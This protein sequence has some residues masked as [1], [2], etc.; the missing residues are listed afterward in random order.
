MKKYFFLL[1]L[2]VFTTIDALAQHSISGVVVDENQEVLIGVSVLVKGSTTSVTITDVNGKYSF[3][4]VPASS[5]LVFSYVGKITQEQRITPSMS[6]LNI[7]MQSSA[8][9]IDE[10]VVTAMGIQQEKKRMN[11]AV[12]SI[13]SDLLTEN[14]SQNFVNALQGKIAG[15]SVTNSSG[16]P[17]SGTQVIIRGISSMNN[18]Q[19]NEPLFILDGIPLA[20]KGSSAADINPN[21]IE[22]VTVLKGAAAAALYGQDAANGVIMITTKK[23]KVGKITATANVSGQYDTP[24][25]LQQ[26]QTSYAPGSQGFYVDK[27]FGGWGPLLNEGQKTY[28]NVDHFLRNGFYQKYDLSFSGGSEKFYT[29][30][31]INLSKNNGIVPN[32]YL[33]KWGVMLKATYQPINSL[34]FNFS[35]NIQENT[36]QSFSSTGMSAVYNFPIIYDITDYELINGYPHFFYYNE[37]DGQKYTSPMSPLFSRYNDKGTNKKLRNILNGSLEWKPVRNLN[38]TGRVGYDT[39]AY[40]YDGYTVPRFDDSVV[41]PHIVKPENP[42]ENATPADLAVYNNKLNSYYEFLDKYANTPY[43]SSKDIENMDKDLLG[44]YR[45]SMSRGSLFSA[46]ALATYKIELNENFNIDFLAGTD[47]KMEESFSTSNSGRDFIIPGTYSLSNTNSNY[48]FLGDRTAEHRLKRMYGYFGEIRGDYKGLASLSVTSRWDWS[49]TILTNPYYYPS[50]TGGL[51]FSELFNLGSKVFNYGKLRGNYAVVGKDAGVYLYDRRFKQFATFPDNGYG[52]DPTLSSADRNLMPEMSYSWEIGADLRFFDNRTR[53]DLAYYSVK[54][55]NQI[56][57]VRVSPSSGYILQT[58]NEGAIRNQGVEFSL[59]QDIIRNRNLSWTTILNFGMN[60]GTVTNLPEEVAEITGTQYGDIYTSAYL[61]G[62]TTGISGKDY[63]RTEEGKIIVG[64]DGYPKIDPN[65]NKYIGNREPLFH[66]GITNTFK[67]KK[68]MLSFLFEGRLG[69]DMV[70]VTGRGLISNGQSKMLETYRGRQIVVDGVVQHPDGSYEPNSTPI[71][72]DNP[73]IINYFYA[74]SSNFVEDGSYIRLSYLTMDYDLSEYVRKT[75]FT[76]LRFTVT[77][78]NL[79]L[80]TRYTGAD[81][82][83]NA[84]TNAGGTGS[85]G[86]DNFAV[87]STTSFNFGLTATF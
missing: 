65:K 16:S 19:S 17:N 40:S 47:L 24:T 39:N 56:V 48:I 35:A 3:S 85:A 23:G 38:I 26:L 36:S 9:G 57:T 37:G 69:G 74:V 8:H 11:F 46:S 15:L 70:N 62:S 32:D 42:A 79:F 72:L 82:N 53:L 45:T 83:L 20:G 64:S 55:D 41:L 4:S 7:T 78:K 12:Q 71:S 84:D 66:S 51:L 21:D 14:K 49:S 77:G 29:Y 76:S 54:A 52:I 50:I 6:V 28:D 73:T 5:T 75:P 80:L 86:I 63:L 31:S 87:P 44:S 18:G 43:L 81:P 10:V 68:W 1:L 61:G 67:Y 33:N 22:N 2:L 58:R 25:R 60:R 27:A 59:A 34:T 13:N 30:T